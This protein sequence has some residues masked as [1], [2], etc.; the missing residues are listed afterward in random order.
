MALLN[1]QTLRNYFKKGNLP[2]EQ[3]FSDLIDSSV[4][5]VDDGI[6]K[7]ANYGLKLSPVGYTNKLISFFENLKSKN[8][9][10]YIS[11]NNNDIPGLSIQENEN[12]PRIVIK[13]GGNVGIGVTNPKYDLEIDGTVAAK[14][15]IGTF[16]KGKV[17][18]DGKWHDILHKLDKPCAFE[19]M[20]RIDGIK[21]SGKYALIHATAINTFGG[22]LSFGKI[23]KTSA[24]YGSFFNK[25]QIRWYGELYNYSLQIKTTR[26]F[27]I[28][29]TIG[30][31]IS[32]YYRITDL[33][34][35]S[36]K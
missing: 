9:S 1:R 12:T 23:N 18:G 20:A 8:P 27:G 7:E 11:L 6:S 21:G 31:P 29:E 24:C 26:H 3:Q 15:R 14:C 2:T 36:F 19:I 34:G 28:D 35:E 22:R 10:W 13:E 33:M 16:S 4:N 17:P 25:I 30:E 32:I 5:I